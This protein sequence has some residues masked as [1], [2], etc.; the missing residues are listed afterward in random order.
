[1]K[2]KKNLI[3]DQKKQHDILAALRFLENL[4]TEISIATNIED[5]NDPAIL[6]KLNEVILF[7]KKELL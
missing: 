4:K 5:I 1:M 6:N 7:L 2:T 3:E